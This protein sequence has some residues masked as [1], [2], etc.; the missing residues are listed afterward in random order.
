MKQFFLSVII[1]NF[2]KP[3]TTPIY[4]QTKALTAFLYIPGIYLTATG[5]VILKPKNLFEGIFK[6]QN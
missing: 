5:T 6:V 2:L 1:S 4:W 3:W